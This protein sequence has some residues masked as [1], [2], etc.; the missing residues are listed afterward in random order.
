MQVLFDFLVGAF[1]GAVCSWVESGA[2]ILF[3]ME[4]VCQF[5]QEM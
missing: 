2:D 1:A 4:E 3:D 5:F